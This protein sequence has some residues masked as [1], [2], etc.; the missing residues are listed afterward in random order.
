MA[1]WIFSCCD[2]ITN[3]LLQHCVSSQD[4]LYCIFSYYSKFVKGKMFPL[5]ITRCSLLTNR[6]NLSAVPTRNSVWETYRH[7][8]GKKYDPPDVSW[9]KV[10]RT[11]FTKQG[12]LMVTNE[13]KKM[14]KEMFE[15][16]MM[17]VVK[18]MIVDYHEHFDTD[19]SFKR[20]RVTCDSAYGDGY[21]TAKFE[22]SKGGHAL[23]TGVL[24]NRVPKDGLTMQAGFAGLAGPRQYKYLHVQKFYNWSE[25]THLKLRFRADGRTYH[26]SISVA[27]NNDDMCWFDTYLYPL[28]THGGPYWQEVSIPFID[29]IHSNKG[30]AQD[31]QTGLQASIVNFVSIIICDKINGPFQIEIDY[32]GLY[33]DKSARNYREIPSPYE[34]YATP[35]L[36]LQPKQYS[37]R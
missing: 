33:Q 22:R 24:D 17:K 8:P 27:Q 7:G 36:K 12:L 35:Q 3:I 28:Y 19:E 16:P 13:M 21:S 14:A 25:Y 6:H 5:R 26:V 1:A 29:F 32:I 4:L 9:S 23:F 34:Q 2:N 31:V 20:W 10:L 11:A 37:S 30:F 15:I 18:P